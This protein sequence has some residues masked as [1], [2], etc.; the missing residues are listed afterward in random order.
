MEL[1]RPARVALMVIAL[2]ALAIVA[3][4]FAEPWIA[5][6]REIRGE[7]YRYARTATS[8]WSGAAIP[9][10]AGAV[11]LSGLVGVAG[12]GY[13]AGLARVPMM[14]LFTGSAV[15]L[16]LLG[17][18]AWPVA[19]HGHASSVELSAGWILL[20][21]LV[22]SVAVFVAAAL[23]TSSM[24]RSLAI[25]AA[26]AVVTVGLGAT[27]RSWLLSEQEGDG[28]HWSDG[29]YVAQL[30]PSSPDGSLTLREGRYDLGTTWSGAWEWSGWTVVLIDDP[31]CPT[32]R[33][34]YHVHDA[35]G[36]AI[37]F[38][39]LVDTCADGSRAA[40]LDGSVWR[41]TE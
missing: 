9:V 2:G 16:G 8:G 15:A 20:L 17:A 32:A 24:P 26:I 38:V 23:T 18:A 10:L 19:H 21:A 6:D 3:L 39:K 34:T 41:R 37:R 31:A 22:V 35:G 12:L 25:G 28:R 14:V 1:R 7:G 29:V 27:T 4:S 40:V 11:V 30:G 5:H 36:T 33:G 13:L